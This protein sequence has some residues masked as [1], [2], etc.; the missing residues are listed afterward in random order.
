MDHR[1]LEAIRYHLLNNVVMP[2]TLTLI[3]HGESES[4]A[5]KRLAEKKGTAVVGE[6]E[7]M[8]VHTSQRRLTARGVRQAKRAG[9]WLRA[10]FTRQAL[11]EERKPFDRVVGYF[12]PYARA[13]E[14]A[15]NLD[16]PITWLPD[17]RLA[18][19]NWGELDQLPY[20][21]RVRKYGESM[22]FREKHGMFWPAANGETLQA[23]STRRWQ[24]FYK[25]RHEH[26]NDDVVEVSHGETILTDRFMLERWM[27][28]E[29]V[30]MMLATDTRYSKEILGIET[31]W[32]NKLIN[33]RIVQYTRQRPDNT[34]ANSYQQV[35]LIAPS[36]PD[37]PKFNIDWRPI[38]RR[39]FSSNE[40][41]EYVEQFPHFLEDA[42]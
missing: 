40:L 23:L 2:R 19:R 29:I 5:A 22:K 18:E 3:R 15:G 35:R 10:H 30:R 7:L 32:A 31:D 20:D 36:R 9:E 16:L 17:A 11:L 25:L 12:S 41:L 26:S 33:C 8:A 42:A 39:K 24:H 1:I 37:D 28:E 13:M 34:W 14:T 27:P 38:V 4:N 21:D 6:A